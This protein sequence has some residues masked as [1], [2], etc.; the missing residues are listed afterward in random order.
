MKKFLKVKVTNV[1]V[2]SIY[3]IKGSD[4]I[5]FHVCQH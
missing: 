4:L 2:E 1:T 3:G 5:H